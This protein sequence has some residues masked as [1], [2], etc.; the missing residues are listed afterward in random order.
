MPMY[1]KTLHDVK[2][3]LP[4]I[5]CNMYTVYEHRAI[6]KLY[7]LYKHNNEALYKI[8]QLTRNRFCSYDTFNIMPTYHK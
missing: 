3:K 6:V 5:I 7:N 1:K 8:N 4:V 2:K